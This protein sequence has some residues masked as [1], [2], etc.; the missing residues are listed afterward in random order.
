MLGRIAKHYDGGVLAA[1]GDA[2]LDHLIAYCKT[3]RIKPPA[4][5]RPFSIQFTDADGNKQNKPFSDCTEV[6]MEWAARGPGR[7]TKPK[8]APPPPPPPPDT[9]SSRSAGAW[10]EVFLESLHD[11]L[12]KIGEGPRVGSGVSKE[13]DGDTCF[14]SVRKIDFHHIREVAQA[15]LD[16]I[17]ATLAPRPPWQEPLPMPPPDW[18]KPPP[19][20]SP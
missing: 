3:V 10:K 17:D 9:G 16:A 12:W 1:E 5:P 15:L 7:R 14:F 19:K 2:R 13:F 8:K 4:D 11:T 18:L 6:E 20:G